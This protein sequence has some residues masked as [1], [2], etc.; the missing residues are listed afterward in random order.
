MSTIDKA[1]AVLNAFSPER[2]ELG[3]T[4]ISNLLDMNKVIVHR[5]LQTLAGNNLIEQDEHT[6]RYRLGYGVLKLA[7]SK[8]ASVNFVQAAMPYANRLRDR[9][10]ETCQLL[11]MRRSA[12]VRVYVAQTHYPLRFAGNVGDEGPLHCSASGKVMLAHV[13]PA[14]LDRLLAESCR[15][16]PHIPCPPREELLADY[17]AIR[18]A[19]FAVDDQAYMRDL[20]AIGAPIQDHTGALIATL[21]IGGPVA[22]ITEDRIDELA[23]ALVEATAEIS[24]QL[25]FHRDVLLRPVR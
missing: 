7:G 25:G 5:L 20:R 10:G 21:S 6:L 8:L 19:G 2:P 16:Y 18:T 12:T 22:R 13:D 14:D 24:Q 11:V 3:V 1:I 9:F 15:K 4:E 23:R 17:A